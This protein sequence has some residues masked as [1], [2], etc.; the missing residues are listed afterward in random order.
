[1]EQLTASAGERTHSPSWTLTTE[2][3]SHEKV[4]LIETAEQCSHVIQYLEEC[5]D[6]VALDLEAACTFVLFSLSLSLISLSLFVVSILSC[7]RHLATS[8]M[9]YLS[10]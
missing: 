10:C 1:V 8:P 3:V 6:V 5:C 4:V 7:S 9:V 2:P